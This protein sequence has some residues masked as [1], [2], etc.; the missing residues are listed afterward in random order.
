LKLADMPDWPAMLSRAEAA[1]YVGVSVET[2]EAEMVEG[3]WPEGI[4]RGAK[5]GKLT[6]SRAGMSDASMQPRSRPW[7][8]TIRR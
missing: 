1:A 2:F 8:V 7:R 5:G 3:K 6:C 4:P